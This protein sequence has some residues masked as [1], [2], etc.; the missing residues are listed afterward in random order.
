MFRGCKGWVA[1]SKL[2][3][4]IDNVYAKFDEDKQVCFLSHPLRYTLGLKLASVEQIFQVAI[5]KWNRSS[6][7]LRITTLVAV[8]TKCK[9]LKAFDHEDYSCADFSSAWVGGLS[10]TFPCSSETYEKLFTTRWGC[11]SSCWCVPVHG[12]LANISFVWRTR[13]SICC[14]QNDDDC[15]ASKKAK[16][17]WII[18][19][20]SSFACRVWVY[21]KKAIRL[22]SNGGARI[23][24]MRE[25]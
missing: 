23:R 20:F 24:R 4:N 1:K 6:V 8:W 13:F 17:F 9:E 3:T 5:F 16:I 14:K 2:N 25:R 11:Y 7:K 10:S 15:W 12:W 19:H 21:K 18:S 22:E